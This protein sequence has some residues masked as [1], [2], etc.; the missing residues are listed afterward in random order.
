MSHV[1]FMQLVELEKLDKWYKCLQ[2]DTLINFLWVPSRF[3]LFDVERFLKL[4]EGVIL[5]CSIKLD[6]NSAF[7]SQWL[8]LF[9]FIVK[10]T[11]NMTKTVTILHVEMHTIKIS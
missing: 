2:V 6:T 4:E 3:G 9:I 10:T 7:T 5:L 1:L 11:T 8:H